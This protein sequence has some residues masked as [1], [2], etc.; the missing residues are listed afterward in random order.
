MLT[1]KENKT[2]Y[3]YFVVNE[4]GDTLFEYF[5]EEDAWEQAS[6]QEGCHVSRLQLLTE[7]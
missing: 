4:D 1:E 5:N 6:K 7:D 2:K 3:V